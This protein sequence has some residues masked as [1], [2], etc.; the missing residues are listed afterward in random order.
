[1]NEQNNNI[2]PTPQ[3]NNIPS[4]QPVN[5]GIVN[6]PAVQSATQPVAEQ[7]VSQQF[8]AAA[9]IQAAPQVQQPVNPQ[10]SVQPTP[11]QPVNDVN[12][13]QYQNV[14]PQAP[15]QP[16]APQAPIESNPQQ[17]ANANM[18]QPV[19][20]IQ[21]AMQQPINQM[22]V[23]QPSSVPNNG[24]FAPSVPIGNNDVTNVGFVATGYEMPKKK[25]KGLIIGIVLVIIV[26]LA[27]LGYFVIYPF[28]MKTYFNDPKNV[29]ET[30]IKSAFKSISTTTNDLVHNKAIYDINVTF[31]SNIETFKDFSG[32]TF[33]VNLGVDP[34]NKL[35]QEEF[36]IS[37]SN[38]KTDYFY[39]YYLKN[40]KI[41]ESYS[42]SIYKDSY[43]YRGEADPEDAN[44][45]FKLFSSEDLFETSNKLDNE[46]FEYLINKLSDTIVGSIDENKLSKEDSSITVNGK[47]LKVTNN[48]YTIDNEAITNTIKYFKDEISSDDKTLDIIAKLMDVEKSEIKEAIKDIEIDKDDLDDDFG[49][50]ISIYT[51]GTKNEIV[52]F[53][54]NSSDDD[55]DIHYYTKDDAFEFRMRSNSENEY[56]GKMEESILEAT[57]KK[58]GN[59]TKI[60]VKLDD[61]DIVEVTLRQF[62]DKGIDFDYTIKSETGDITGTIKYASDINDDRAKFSLDASVRMGK[63]YITLNV[64][65]DENWTADVANINTDKAVTLTDEE[66]AKVQEDLMNSLAETPLLKSFFTSSGDYDTDISDYYNQ[67]GYESPD[68]DDWNI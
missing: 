44:D 40:N 20:D 18:Q 51:Y 60:N 59:N 7:V 55:L 4:Q 16:V 52:G 9:P 11:V 36:G 33:N 57:G 5:T 68:D 46:E 22:P 30:T 12:A 15:V 28:I 2:N 3:Q 66:I 35:L 26:A 50:V 58:E 45:L 25:N 41:Y 34:E 65:C 10:Q 49:A 56:T 6:Q 13:Q 39:K 63:E 19:Q 54:L 37:D 8:Q 23:N 62:D 47:T 42:G 1:M 14:A 27:A 29:Y 53:A 38:T 48:K 32:Y 61:K 24:V 31:D 43:I 64:E 17:M 67:N 21:P